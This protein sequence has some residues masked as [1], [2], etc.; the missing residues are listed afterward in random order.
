MAEGPARLA[1]LNRKGAIEVGNDADLCVLAPDEQ[2]TV[3]P[4]KLHHRHPGT[5]YDGRTLRGVVRQTWLRGQPIDLAE[6]RGRLLSAGG[7]P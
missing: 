5:P 3:D 1:G 2:F 6:P 7:A 4:A